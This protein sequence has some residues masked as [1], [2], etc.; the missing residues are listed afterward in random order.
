MRSNYT[1]NG[2][3]ATASAN[4]QAAGLGGLKFLNILGKLDA[5]IALVA[6]TW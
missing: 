5:P 4:S 1:I 6:V 3:R 2:R